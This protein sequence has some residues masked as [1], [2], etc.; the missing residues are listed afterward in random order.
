MVDTYPSPYE[1]RFNASKHQIR[2]IGVIRLEHFATRIGRNEGEVGDRH[3]TGLRPIALNQKHGSGAKRR[4]LPGYADQLNWLR[5]AM[6]KLKI[7]EE[8]FKGQSLRPCEP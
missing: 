8:L 2:I 3:T 5:S 4:G 1:S 6:S 7:A